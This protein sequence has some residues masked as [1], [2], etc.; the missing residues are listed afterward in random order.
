MC[1]D[2]KKTY[3]KVLW[4]AQIYNCYN[5]IDNIMIIF[6]YII[7]ISKGT[8]IKNNFNKKLKLLIFFSKKR[9]D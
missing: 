4:K 2:I 5:N 1:W 7:I 8:Y 9:V 3:P 6:I